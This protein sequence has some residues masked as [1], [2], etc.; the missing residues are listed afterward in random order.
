MIKLNDAI[1]YRKGYP[2]IFFC[3]EEELKNTIAALA[4][5]HGI[6]PERYCYRSLKN[7]VELDLLANRIK[8]K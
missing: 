6:S 1:D 8:K 2:G 4:K 3:V 5:E 7:T